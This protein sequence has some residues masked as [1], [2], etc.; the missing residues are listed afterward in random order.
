LRA[1][2]R[3]LEGAKAALREGRANAA[4]DALSDHA[5]RFPAGELA[6]EAE[7]L[8]IDLALVRGE[9][10]RAWATARRLLALPSASQYRE[11]LEALLRDGERRADEPVGANRART[12][13]TERR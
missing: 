11:R 5:R 13:M 12:D 10:S 6:V 9:R 8:R 1:E 7:L 4:A 3:L 2:L